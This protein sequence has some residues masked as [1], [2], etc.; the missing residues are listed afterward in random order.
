MHHYS[1]V[2]LREISDQL[3]IVAHILQTNPF[4][5]R[6]K[7][8]RQVDKALF[9]IETFLSPEF[10]KDIRTWKESFD[11]LQI[12]KKKLDVL[13]KTQEKIKSLELEIETLKNF[14]RPWY[15]LE[16]S[17]RDLLLQNT[18]KARIFLENHGRE[19]EAPVL[20]RYNRLLEL[21]H[22]LIYADDAPR[23]CDAI[24]HH[25]HK[26]RYAQN[27]SKIIEKI[28]LI[29]AQIKTVKRGFW[30][31]LVSCILI[32]TIPISA[33]FTFT[34]W[35]RKRR[36]EAHLDTYEELKQREQNRLSLADDGTK[37][38]LDVQKVIGD[39][40]YDTIHDLF[41]E[42]K[43]LKA[44]FY[45][46]E[47]FLSVCAVILNYIDTSKEMLS[48][49]FEQMPTQ[50]HNRVEWLVKN[51]EKYENAQ[52][53]LESLQYQKHDFFLQKKQKTKGYERDVLVESIQQLD[54]SMKFLKVIP[55]ADEHKVTFFEICLLIPEYFK[56]VRETIFYINQN[57]DVDLNVWY[58]SQQKI[59][60]FSNQVALFV[61]D[62][63]IAER[64][65]MDSFQP[66]AV[67]STT[68]TASHSTNEHQFNGGL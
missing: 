67:P 55:F 54:I 18:K 12:L 13:D 36:L 34:L 22:L 40:S 2:Q 35:Q 27:L 42:V 68:E 15:L 33:P 23:L 5:L 29:H 58:T 60:E 43:E 38:T 17:E 52:K 57:Y 4:Y 31:A 26:E 51:V 49:L 25:T 3:S 6:S 47:R 63:E 64:L 24:L 19:S 8:I 32:A 21:K 48:S 7:Q 44:E 61:L 1:L 66:D 50:A 65:Q 20:E 11:G 10:L 37:I 41:M 56:K 62:A 45:D 16:D 30:V 46:P 14:L 28:D 53:Q 59:Q 9:T 39:I